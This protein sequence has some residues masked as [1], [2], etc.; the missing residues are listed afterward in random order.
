MIIFIN[1]EIYAAPCIEEIGND[2]SNG[3]VVTGGSYKIRITPPEYPVVVEVIQG[4][5]FDNR[6]FCIN[7]EE[8]DPIEFWGFLNVRTAPLHIICYSAIDPSISGTVIPSTSQ[9]GCWQ[10]GSTIQT[11]SILQDGKGAIENSIDSISD[12]MAISEL[13]NSTIPSTITLKTNI[14]QKFENTT[15]SNIWV[16]LLAWFYFVFGL[17]LTIRFAFKIGDR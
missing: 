7:V 4:G 16:N 10:K 2:W 5:Y 12:S 1:P 14:T 8:R 11:F 17:F 9:N 6:S 3:A 15:T 13:L